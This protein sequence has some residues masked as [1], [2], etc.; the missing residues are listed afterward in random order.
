MPDRGNPR[1]RID[2]RILETYRRLARETDMKI[3]ELMAAVLEAALKN[4][5]LIIQA[6]EEKRRL[7]DYQ[8]YTVFKR[9]RIAL[10]HQSPQC[11]D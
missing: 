11:V 3:G 10:G 2:P 8:A 5:W 6:I 1:V 9:V 7:T 4:P